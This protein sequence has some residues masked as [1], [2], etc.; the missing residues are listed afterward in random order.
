MISGPIDH[1]RTFVKPADWDD[2]KHGHCGDLAV[3]VEHYHGVNYHYSMWTPTVEELKLLAEGGRVRL[4]C[5]GNQPPVALVV[6][7]NAESY[8]GRQ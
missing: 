7:S 8:G 5:V 6:V 3:M 4:T 1:A 2:E